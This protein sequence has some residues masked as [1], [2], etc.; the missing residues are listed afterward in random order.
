MQTEQL[1][2]K[3]MS[4]EEFGLRPEILRAVAEKKYTIPTP[5]QEKAIPIVLE[6][7][8][9][10]GCAQTGTGKTAAFALPILHRLQ[11]TPWRGTGR[12]PIR[13]LVLTPTRELASQIAEASAR[14]ESTRPSSTPSS[15]AAL[16][17]DRN[18]RRSG[19]GFDILVATPGRLL[20]LMSQGL[21]QLR[22][23]E[24]FVLDEADRMLD[25]GFIHDIRRVIDQLPA[26][27]QTLFF[28]A[29]MPREI[30]GLADTILRD[31]IRW[32]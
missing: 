14:T 7:K 13:V 3:K 21:V 20:D 32:P 29:T 8:D 12:R 6:G 26:K 1:L 4:F 27:R 23:V 18:R 24:T 31:P 10:V 22:S 17:R 25:M 30:Q 19:G 28:S 11:G 15:S 2:E 9:L 5:I 16:T